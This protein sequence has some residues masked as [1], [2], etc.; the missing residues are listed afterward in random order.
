MASGKRQYGRDFLLNFQF[1]PAC[2]QKP[3][4]LPPISDVV[5][6]KVSYIQSQTFRL[7][8]YFVIKKLKAKYRQIKDYKYLSDNQLLQEVL[9]MRL[10]IIE[11]GCSHIASLLFSKMLIYKLNCYREQLRRLRENTLRVR[12]RSDRE[13]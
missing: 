7:K 2:V 8:Y 12:Q 3:E 5:L 4:G 6:D 11:N 10:F 13:L 9:K 1:M